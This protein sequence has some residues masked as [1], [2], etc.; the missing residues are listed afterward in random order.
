MKHFLFFCCLLLLVI[1]LKARPILQ[2]G[3]ETTDSLLARVSAEISNV[4]P[5]RA[6]ELATEALSLSRNIGYSKGEAMSCFYI[7]QV[8]S[9]LGDYQRSIEYLSLSEQERYSRDNAV[10]QSEIS[11][12]KG[13]VYYM[14]NLDK[15]SFH[16]FQK[17]HEYAIRIKDKKERDRYTSL[18]YENLGIAYDMIKQ[19]PDSSFYWMKKNEKLLTGAEEK[20]IFRNKINLYSHFGEYYTGKQQYDTAAL[21]FEKA[22]SLIHQYSY[23][24]SSWLYQRWGDLQRKRGNRDSAMILY[25]NGL[26]NLKTTNIKNELPAFYKRISEIYAER[27]EEDSARRYHEKE[28]QISNELGK[29]RNAAA[30]EAFAMLLKE[31]QKL[32]KAKLRRTISLVA[33]LF[34]IA[35]SA[36]M[37]IVYRSIIKRKKK[38]SEVSELK[39][40]LNDAFEEVVELARK[41]ESSFLPRF[42]EVYPEFS[43]NLLQQ[44]PNLTNAEL[45]LSAM[46][47]LHFPSKEIAECMFITHR[48][49]QTSKSRL[50][51]KLGIS[52]E[53]D[54]YHYFKSFS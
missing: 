52:S 45:R 20:S 49:V 4:N 11:R 32:S 16:E 26:E 9:Y 21:Y 37:V 47:F 7:G 34:T 25:R 38:E 23:H 10:M 24:Y 39:L 35:L 22:D 17:A 27:G 50:R 31:E 43:R 54:L 12:I 30:E 18:A 8:L 33:I 14:L 48:S 15:A 3:T 28:L 1:G 13:Q 19:M 41:N 46:I 29:A 2:G 51:K 42:R 44:H 5:V 40:K 36:S 53:A 6:L